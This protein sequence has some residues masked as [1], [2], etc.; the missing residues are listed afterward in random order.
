MYVNIYYIIFI[1]L[2]YFLNILRTLKY[3][4]LSSETQIT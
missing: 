2:E 1:K 4:Q 3:N